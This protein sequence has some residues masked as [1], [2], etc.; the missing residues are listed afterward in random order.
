MIL[1]LVVNIIT[2]MVILTTL[3]KS[4]LVGENTN[5]NIFIS[6]QS[7]SCFTDDMSSGQDIWNFLKVQFLVKLPLSSSLILSWG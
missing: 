3:Q 7:F 1:I 5:W 4:S 6:S 2:M